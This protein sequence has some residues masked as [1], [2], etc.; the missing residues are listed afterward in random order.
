M[1]E[2]NEEIDIMNE[3]DVE[4]PAQ[5]GFEVSRQGETE[6]NVTLLEKTEGYVS[7]VPSIGI[8]TLRVASAS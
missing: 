4:F 3:D 7:H 2:G 8:P 5:E 6:V 1:M